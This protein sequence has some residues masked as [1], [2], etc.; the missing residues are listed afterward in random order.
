MAIT[1]PDGAIEY[2]NRYLR[3]ML[4][5]RSGEP[6]ELPFARCETGCDRVRIRGGSGEALDVLYAVCPLHDDTGVAAG[7]VH[8]LQYLGDEHH[9]ESLA[10]LA[11][12]DSLTGLPNRNLFNDRLARALAVGKRNRRT[13]ALLYIDIDHF[14]QVNDAF[15]H[16]TGDELLRAV[17]ARLA[18]SVRASDTVARWGGDEFVAI[19]EGVADQQSAACVASKLVAACGEPYI[20]RG[21][22]CRITLS[23]GASCHPRDGH[24]PAAL[25]ERADRA[26]YEV[27][28]RG[29]NG[30]RIEESPNHYGLSAA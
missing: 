25:L 7:F 5:V 1:R 27:K 10:R 14:K 17:A 3:G 22:E 13:F 9:I 26:M 11:F 16:E 21:H 24:D 20:V 30:Y 15:G 29:R 12:Y 19:L 28:A 6:I 18:Q 4:G 8:L 23:L 2:A